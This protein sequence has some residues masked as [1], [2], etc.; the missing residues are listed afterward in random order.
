[1]NRNYVVNI[2]RLVLIVIIFLGLNACAGKIQKSHAV[3]VVLETS[4]GDIVVAVYPDKA[5][6]SANQ[7]LRLVDDGIYN[8]STFYRAARPDNYPLIEVEPGKI[9]EVTEGRLI[10]G[11]VGSG[12]PNLGAIG[13]ES[14]KQTG[15]RH[16]SG[17]LSWAR[18]EVGTARSEFFICIDDVPQLDYG[19]FGSL[20]RKGYAAFGL[21]VQG[22]PIVRA[23]NQ[24]V[25]NGT[26]KKGAVFK[27]HGQIK[28]G[29]FVDDQ[30]F[31]WGVQTITNPIRVLR[32]YRQ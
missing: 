8:K 17:S 25:T 6:L 22:M 31:D 13:H 4:Q 27:M 18:A 15:L 9:I 32:A 30:D 10:Q 11:G 29:K 12:F 2:Y 19:G 7:F 26:V 14:T 1:M 24:Q 28:N 16:V 20:D 3:N 5:P 21:V 23:I